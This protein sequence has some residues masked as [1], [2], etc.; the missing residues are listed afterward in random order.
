MHCCSYTS[1]WQLLA[2]GTSSRTVVYAQPRVLLGLNGR[3]LEPQ[4]M[5]WC[6][7]RGSSV[8]I[9]RQYSICPKR[10][11][12]V[13]RRTQL[14]RR[15][16]GRVLGVARGVGNLDFHDPLLGQWSGDRKENV[17]LWNVSTRRKLGWA[18]R[19]MYFSIFHL[20]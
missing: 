11:I 12:P 2:V 6:V 3:V 7:Y 4:D 13:P 15:S 8:G 20:G 18:R 10:L 17:C 14:M 16:L 5:I 19:D 9:L 1:V